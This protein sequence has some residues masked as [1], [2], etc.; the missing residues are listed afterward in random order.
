MLPDLI[1]IEIPV[2]W[3]G[4]GNYFCLSD[5]SRTWDFTIDGDNSRPFFQLLLH[6]WCES[7]E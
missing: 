4:L 1:E 5:N 7:F 2:I 3:S 6:D